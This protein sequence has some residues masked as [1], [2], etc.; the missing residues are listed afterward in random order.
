LEKSRS[1]HSMSRRIS[2]ETFDSA[3]REKYALLIRRGELPMA[4][5]FGFVDSFG[6]GV[7]VECSK[8]RRKGFVRPWLYSLAKEHDVS[9]FYC[10][11]CA[12]FANPKQLRANLVLFAAA[13]ES[14]AEKKEGQ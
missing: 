14:Y 10:V 12:F 6:D 5:V 1:D 2:R 4:I 13:I 11:P 7:I 3:L 8:C 9:V